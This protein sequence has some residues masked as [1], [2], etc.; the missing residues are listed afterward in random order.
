MAIVCGLAKQYQLHVLVPYYWTLTD[1]DALGLFR[2]A[3]SILIVAVYAGL[4][5]AARPIINTKPFT[6]LATIGRQSLKCFCLGVV[7]TYAFTFLWIGAG[8][9]YLAYLLLV[10]LAVAVTCAAAVFWDRRK[11]AALGHAGVTS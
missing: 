6:L 11:T 3:H 10:T 8:R 5:V 7:I 2:V 4:L 9:S 1:R